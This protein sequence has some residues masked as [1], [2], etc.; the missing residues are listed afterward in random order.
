MISFV[1]HLISLGR[2]NPS[3]QRHRSNEY[4]RVVPPQEGVMACLRLWFVS[5]IALASGG[6][7][8][9]PQDPPSPDPEAVLDHFLCYLVTPALVLTR[10]VILK[11][12][13]TVQ[14]KPKPITVGKRTMLCN[15]VEKAFGDHR[16]ARKKPEAHL[17]CY[18]IQP[19]DTPAAAVAIRNQ[20]HRQ[21]L[22]FQTDAA[23]LLC[24]PSGK[25]RTQ[26]A[27]GIPPGLDHFK[28]Y[29]PQG[30]INVNNFAVGLQDQFLTKEK[31]FTVAFVTA[32]CNPVEK[33]VLP[34]D[35]AQRRQRPG[36]IDEAIRAAPMLNGDA[37]LVCYGLEPIEYL[38]ERVLIT[39]QFE[40]GAPIIATRTQMLCVPS[41]KRH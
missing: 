40:R 32:L 4:A 29:V 14:G 35:I 8:L 13:F 33:A 3:C 6:C 20:F 1:D 26:P 21:P 31:N 17:V 10:E 11:D 22:N 12:Q 34:P 7:A 38:E 5:C 23:R 16:T 36:D 25:S 19:D 18:E 39:N 28:C 41:T 15:P 9:P 24:L 2:E 37:H 30:M 27:P